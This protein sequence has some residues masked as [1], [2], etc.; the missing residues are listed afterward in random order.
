MTGSSDK[1]FYVPRTSAHTAKEMYRCYGRYTGFKAYNGEK[2][3]DWDKLPERIKRAWLAAAVTYRASAF[4]TDGE[5]TNAINHA[6]FYNDE[7]VIL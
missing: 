4:S 6:R 7:P 1:P 5:W 3:P 2:M